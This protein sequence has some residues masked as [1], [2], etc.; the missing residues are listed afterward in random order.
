[1]VCILKEMFVLFNFDSAGSLN[2]T[3]HL[4][5]DTNTSSTIVLKK[6]IG[7]DLKTRKLTY[8]IKKTKV[9]K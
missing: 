5:W 2:G 4:C 6:Y 8:S 1:M 9:T 7:S 3:V